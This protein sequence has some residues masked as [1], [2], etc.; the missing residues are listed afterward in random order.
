MNEFISNSSH[1]QNLSPRN[2]S[3]KN[4]YFSLSVRNGTQCLCPLVISS[5]L[6]YCNLSI[7]F[8]IL[9]S[10]KILVHLMIAHTHASKLLYMTSPDL[11]SLIFL[12]FC[13]SMTLIANILLNKSQVTN[14]SL[15]KWLSS[16]LW[17]TS[18]VCVSYES[19]V[20]EKNNLMKSGIS[21]LLRIKNFYSQ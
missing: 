7:H 3:M 19:S 18:H 11:H 9:L 14:V 6:I 15:Q 1:D 20:V 21:P 2:L 12:K 16:K 4:V 13:T 17:L 8:L 10:D 5:L